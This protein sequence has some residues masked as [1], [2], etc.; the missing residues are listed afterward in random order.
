[1]TN[2]IIFWLITI[3]VVGSAL[4]VVLLRNIVHSALFLIVT[5]VGVSG[6]YI[7]LQADFLAAVQL[8]VYAGAVAILIVFGVMLTVRGDIKNSNM[9]NSYKL[10]GGIVA[11]VF[12][13]IVERIILKTD[14]VLSTAAMPESTVGPIADSLL[15]NFVIPFE[16]AAVLLLV[17]MVGAILLARGEGKPQ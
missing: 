14:W 4:A 16:V 8:L 15:G 13:L 2:P 1:M 3:L 12:F 11:L 10:S 6:L 17:A 7:L 5:F 9:F